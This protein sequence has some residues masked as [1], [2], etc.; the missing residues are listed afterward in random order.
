VSAGGSIVLL[1]AESVLSGGISISGN[2]VNHAPP[3]GLTGTA[4]TFAFVIR[5]AAGVI[6]Q[7][8]ISVQLL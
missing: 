6:R 4:D 3:A 2:I 8:V 5:S 7:G 1:H